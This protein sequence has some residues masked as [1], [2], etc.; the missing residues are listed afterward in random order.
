MCQCLLIASQEKAG[1]GQWEREGGPGRGCLALPS[2]MI[3]L[4]LCLFPLSAWWGR[5][6]RLRPLVAEAMPSEE[7]SLQVPSAAAIDRLPQ[8]PA[9]LRD[10]VR[11]Q[12]ALSVLRWQRAERSSPVQNRTARVWPPGK[13]HP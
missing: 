13:A 10:L 1:S 2:H 5:C 7:S 4:F 12:G 3:Q 6:S 9:D 11:E 8:N